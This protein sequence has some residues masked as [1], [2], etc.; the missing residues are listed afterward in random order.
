MPYVEQI[1]RIDRT[2]IDTKGKDLGS[3]TVYGVTSVSSKNANPERLLE[4]N[5]GHWSIEN[6]SHYVRDV[7]FAED[8]SR[9]RKGAGAHVFSTLRNV[10]IGL[11]RLA[12]VKNI[13]KGIRDMTHGKRRNVLRMIGIT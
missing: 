3:E 11:L 10:V 12:G 2:R 9:V 1:F 5:R 6:K 13:A 4:L 8:A 7:T